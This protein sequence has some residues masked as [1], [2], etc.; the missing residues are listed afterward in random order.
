[1]E[2]NSHIGFEDFIRENLDSLE[3]P[4][5]N[6]NWIRLEKDLPRKSFFTNNWQKIVAV[7]VIVATV[8]ISGVYL[9]NNS[10]KSVTN[11]IQPKI[12]NSD[13]IDK[14]NLSIAQVNN[15]SNIIS[16]NITSHKKVDL[17]KEQI[18]QTDNSNQNQNNLINTD[19]SV[20]INQNSSFENESTI[21]LVP[22]ASFTYNNEN[23][24]NPLT[25]QF[26]PTL[27]SGSDTILYLWDFGD[28]SKSDDICPIHT[29][30]TN[31]NYNVSLTITFK[32]SKQRTTKIIKDAIK[33]LQTPVAK[34][35]YQKSDNN[36][37]TFKNLSLSSNKYRWYLG[38][39]V[40]DE[41]SPEYTFNCNGNYDVKLIAYNS[42]GCS[43]TIIKNINVEIKYNIQIGNAFSPDGDGIN[44]EFGPG[45]TE[46]LNYTYKFVIYDNKKSGQIIFESNDVHNRWNGNIKGSNQPVEKGTYQW[47]IVGKDKY[48]NSFEKTG[49]VTLI[50]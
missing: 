50:R 19:K 40:I 7:S 26:I 39:E 49:L 15:N 3:F 2:N 11:N 24:C 47:K 6:N 34:F 1:M 10:H 42:N 30:K 22:N 41:D 35:D 4:Y 38:S 31:G 16:N 14:T 37:F 23:G 43:D 12:N 9:F 36:N 46:F 18:I 8:I 45:E 33:V 13:K 28:G 25:V 44:D 29:Y 27:K 5:D 20:S 17:V 21:K 48:G 32:N